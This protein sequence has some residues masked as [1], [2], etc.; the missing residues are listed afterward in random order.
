MKNIELLYNDGFTNSSDINFIV[1]K[2]FDEFLQT[3]NEMNKPFERAE[4]CQNVIQK[5]FYVYNDISTYI[6]TVEFEKGLIDFDEPYFQYSMRLQEK[7]G[8]LCSDLIKFF[9]TEIQSPF[10]NFNME[11]QHLLL[12]S[13]KVYD[14]IFWSS[15]IE[16][17]HEGNLN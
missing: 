17:V 3:I 6:D 11:T 1:E 5:T 8:N 14:I 16:E 2:E 10:N 12:D 7:V 4:Y 9:K 13:L 15:K